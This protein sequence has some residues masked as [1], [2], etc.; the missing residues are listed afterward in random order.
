MHA[1]VCLTRNTEQWPQKLIMQ[2]IPQQLLVRPL[3]GQLLF[4][5]VKVLTLFYE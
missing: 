3:F 5:S 1:V 4:L 2:L